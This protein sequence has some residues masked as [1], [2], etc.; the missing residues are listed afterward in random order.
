MDLN[1]DYEF[2][3]SRTTKQKVPS[4][5]L[6]LQINAGHWCHGQRQTWRDTAK[7]KLENK[8]NSFVVGLIQCAAATKA[9]ELHQREQAELRRQEE[10]RRQKEAAKLAEKRE[11]YKQEKARVDYTAQTVVGLV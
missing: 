1:N 9:H 10:I 3:H 2:G 8:L 11:Q 5:L 6:T 7:S 4:G